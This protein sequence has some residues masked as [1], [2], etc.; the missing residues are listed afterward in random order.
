M[1]VVEDNESVGNL[2]HRKLLKLGYTIYTAKK[3]RDALSLMDGHGEKIR[4]VIT[5]LVMPEMGGLELSRAIKGRYPSVK[6]IALSGY[7]IRYESDDFENVGIT[8]FI[9][10]PFVV[11]T[12]AE[13]V[14]K[15][16]GGKLD[17][18]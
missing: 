15:A 11:Q 1:L 17:L 12:L 16:L 13:A 7:P 18:Y 2:I 6:I 10:K 14:R 5:D 3:G 8:D 9:Q 4:L